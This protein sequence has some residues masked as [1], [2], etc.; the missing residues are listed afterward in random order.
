[1]NE[2]SIAERRKALGLTQERL[3]R[4]IEDR[5]QTT[6]SG[7]L[8]YRWEHGR[9]SSKMAAFLEYALRQIESSSAGE[10]GA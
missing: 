4:R 6:V 10:V 9:L 3:A 8:I 1:M 2:V 7:V 5:T